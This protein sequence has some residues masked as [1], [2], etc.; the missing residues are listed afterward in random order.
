MKAARGLRLLPLL[1]LAALLGGCARAVHRGAVHPA[2]PARIHPGERYVV[3][4]HGRIVEE[5][6]PQPTD[7]VFGVYEYPRILGTLAAAGFQVVGETRPRGADFVA[8]SRRVAE[9]VRGLLAAGVPPQNITV[10][11]FSKG[12]AIAVLASAL[13]REDRVN[14]VFMGICDDWLFPREDVD[15]RGRILSL[16]EASDELGGSC[17]PLFARA[18]AP[19]EHAELR[20]ETG[21]RHGAFYRVRPE[22][23]L[24]VIAWARGEAPPV[25]GS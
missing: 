1:A 4:L 8:Y 23:M 6:G 19:V 7:S 5:Q 20:L 11:G 12:G 13:L 17:A 9:Q 2:I 18:T 16:Y 21:E 10:V 3:Y 15:V 24:P 25:P 22:W 14:F